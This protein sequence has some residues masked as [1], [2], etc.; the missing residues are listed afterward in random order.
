MGT[1]GPT[2]GSGSNSALVPTW[3]NELP[4]GPLPGNGP[5]TPPTDGQDGYAQAS[6]GNDGS[7]NDQIVSAPIQAPPEAERFRSARANFTSFARSGGGNRPALARAVRDYVR[8]GTRGTGNAVT[9]MGP[10]RD[11]ASRALGVFRG[12]QRDGVTDTL[13]QLNLG[14]LVGRST[15]D[16]FIGLT[17]VICRDGGSIDEAIA[18]D[19]WLETVTELDRFAIDDLEALTPDQV[20]EVFL[21]FIT[22]AVEA[23][24]FQEIGVNGF[25]VANLDA[26]Q[27]FEA[28]FRSYIE[29]AIRDSFASDLAQLSLLS[30]GQIRSIVDR[31]YRDAWEL[32]VA[33]GDQ[34]G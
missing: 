29:R 18:R 15:R 30:D 2:K 16:V 7:R 4:A 14:N 23:R 22:H 34:Q 1:S 8:S 27:S 32:L 19:A 28:Q 5:A 26:I 20:R 31:T 3:L 9:R 17:D 6:P 21:A 13:L 12:F 25:K 24:L 11:T 10:S 33:W